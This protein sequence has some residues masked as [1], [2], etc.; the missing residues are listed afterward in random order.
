[1]A[2][3]TKFG[4]RDIPTV[5]DYVDIHGLSGPQ[6]VIT[7]KCGQ[8][9]P[10]IIPG[11]STAAMCPACGKRFGIKGLHVANGEVQI[12]VGLLSDLVMPGQVPRM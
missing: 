3:I 8:S 1:M 9:G 7:C 2:D 6:V 11:L 10:L 4:A 5:G 12:A